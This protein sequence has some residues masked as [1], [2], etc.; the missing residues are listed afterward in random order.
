VEELIY[1]ILIMVEPMKLLLVDDLE[2]NLAALDALLR[3]P[4][5]ESGLEI[6]KASSGRQALELLLEH[7]FALCL[8]DVQ[9]PEMSGFELAELMRGTERTKNVPII[10]V[11]AV[12]RDPNITFKGYE[13]GAVDFLFKPL[14][15]RIVRSKVHVFIELEKQKKLLKLQLQEREEL[16]AA[17]QEQVYKLTLAEASLQKAIQARDEFLSIGSHELKTPITSLK[18]R[19]QIIQRSLANGDALSLDPKGLKSF[20]D[21]SDIQINR[22]VKVVDALLDVS[23]IQA[24]KLEFEFE[25]INLFELL[26]EISHSLSEQ[27]KLVGTEVAFDCDPGLTVFWDRFRIEQIFVNLITNSLKYA[28]ACPIRISVSSIAEKIRLVIED[29]GPG[30]EKKY[31]AKLFERFERATSSRHVSGL[32]LGLFIVKYIV[33]GH[34]G[35]INLISDLGQGTKFVIDLPKDARGTKPIS[36]LR[37]DESSSQHPI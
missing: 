3:N 31:Q 21:Q 33:E 35:E 25:E 7:E 8:L 12:A 4:I 15:P 14:D 32:G 19:I 11:T 36:L 20:F 2:E 24:G 34:Q 1:L 30:I 23:R 9:M 22:M 18:L 13:T 10:F 29:N 6:Y 16:L 5:I 27:A 17:L 28:P 26:D 37:R